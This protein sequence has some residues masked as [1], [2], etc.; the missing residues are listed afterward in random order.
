MSLGDTVRSKLD[1]RCLVDGVDGVDGIEKGSC[2]TSLVG[3]PHPRVIVDL[4]K[5]GAPLGQ[6]RA[7]CDFLF[8]ADPNFVTP[9]EV[10]DHGSP[11]I[12]KAVK[13]L[14]AGAGAADQLAPR[15]SV[16]RFRPVLV[17]RAMRR[18]T[19]YELRNAKVQFRKRPEIVRL[20]LCGEP[21]AAVLDL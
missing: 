14:Q 13:Q 19:Q 21:L 10:K 12:T 16:V 15:G 5:P 4:D 8:F 6:A 7:K 2:G 17:S 1:S 18:D 9:I 20:V 11:K 3:A